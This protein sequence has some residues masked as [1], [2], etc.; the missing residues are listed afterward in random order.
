MNLLRLAKRHLKLTITAGVAALFVATG[1]GAYVVTH[2]PLDAQAHVNAADIAQLK[3][4]D[5]FTNY[6][7]TI[8]YDTGLRL[9]ATI[10][11]A[12][13]QGNSQY[14][15][16]FKVH[17]GVFDVS[18]TADMFISPKGELYVRMQNSPFLA[19]FLQ[20]YLAADSESVATFLKDI[21]NKWIKVAQNDLAGIKPYDQL[22]PCVG[23]L[24]QASLKPN[25]ESAL[26]AIIAK[27]PYERVIKELPSET[28]QNESARHYSMDPKQNFDVIAEASKLPSFK[29]ATAA[30][31]DVVKAAT[32]AA[33]TP[34]DIG[35]QELSET[36][37]LWV[38]TQSNRMLRGLITYKVATANVTVTADYLGGSPVIKE[39][40][41]FQTA[42]SVGNRLQTV[43]APATEDDFTS[44]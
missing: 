10:T 14:H 15:G 6:T 16:V 24:Q 23:A 30:C 39:P 11:G 44:F 36:Y 37:E 8:A 29:Q 27:T 38:S 12:S 13:Q 7:V 35:H 19:G 26:A 2:P 42:S 25:D 5:G 34:A 9:N 1:V 41:E 43:L 32:S 21:D 18:L 33:A 4:M 40:T 31:Q 22:L 17:T 20:G 3:T 28:V